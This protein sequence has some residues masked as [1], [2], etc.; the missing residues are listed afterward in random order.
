MNIM[1]FITRRLAQDEHN[2]AIE[3]RWA[4]RLS[5]CDHAGVDLQFEQMESVHMQQDHSFV[6]TLLSEA[7]KPEK[8]TTISHRN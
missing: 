3:A 5:L 2:K 4:W 7:P 1:T 6:G 8:T